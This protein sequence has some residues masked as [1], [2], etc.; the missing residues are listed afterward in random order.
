MAINR[1]Y[2]CFIVW[3]WLLSC[4]HLDCDR[5]ANS[6]GIGN[7]L[8]DL[9]M[10]NTRNCRISSLVTSSV[11]NA[12]SEELKLQLCYAT[13][14]RACIAYCKYG[15]EAWARVIFTSWKL[16]SFRPFWNSS[17]LVRVLRRRIVSLLTDHFRRLSLNLTQS[18]SCEKKKRLITIHYSFYSIEL[19]TSDLNN[20]I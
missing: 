4:H 20:E 16:F 6:Y 1:L 12:Y 14:R 15:F 11:C 5:R 19:M 8:N 2:T 9:D 7:I 18:N 3:I 10:L 17:K 13:W